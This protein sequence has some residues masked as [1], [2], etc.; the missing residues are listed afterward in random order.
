MPYIQ[1]LKLYIS[2]TTDIPR[3]LKLL[4]DCK[5]LKTLVLVI[6]LVLEMCVET[7]ASL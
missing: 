4:K 5:S 1:Y 7:L 2:K 3:L 6:N